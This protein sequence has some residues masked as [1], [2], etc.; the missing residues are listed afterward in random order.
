MTPAQPSPA[1]GT[2]EGSRLLLAR[3]ASR[4]RPPQPL[5]PVRLKS[6]RVGLQPNNPTRQTLARSVG[7]APSPARP[8]LP[9]S[10]AP[11]SRLSSLPSRAAAR[12]PRPAPLAGAAAPTR[13]PPSLRIGSPPNQS[14]QVA[15]PCHSP[16]PLR[17]RE[18]LSSG[19]RNKQK[20]F[21]ILPAG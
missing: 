1:H 10:S 20:P 9:S 16:C 2:H 17:R 5:H 7:A 21:A 15:R 4:P 19:T 3:V 13:V 14:R 8:H 11:T 12:L 6:E 18:S